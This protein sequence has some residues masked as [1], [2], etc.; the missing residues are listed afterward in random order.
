MQ[1]SNRDVLDFIKRLPGRLAI[2][3]ILREEYLYEVHGPFVAVPSA[4]SPRSF[5]KRLTDG[6]SALTSGLAYWNRLRRGA[7]M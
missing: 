3:Q 6:L 2:G 1:T 5:A 4:Q 7:T